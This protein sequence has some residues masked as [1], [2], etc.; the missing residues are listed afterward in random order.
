MIRAIPL[1]LLMTPMLRA[2]KPAIVQTYPASDP[3]AVA[4]RFLPPGS[5]MAQDYLY[6]FRAGHISRRWPAVL[7]GHILSPDADDIVFAYY[8]FKGQRYME[9]TLFLALLHHAT[10]GYELV[11]TLSYRDQFLFSPHAL[12]IVKLRGLPN[13]A[14][15]IATAMGAALGAR[16]EVFVWREGK[17]W[18][19]IFPPNGSVSYFYLFR[20]P[21]GLMV[22][23]SSF[24]HPG[25]NVSPPPEWFQWDGKKFVRIPTPKDALKWEPLE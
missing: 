4:R 8:T 10:G 17:G 21:S 22:A 13:E 2:S 20:R 7:T 18:L 14:V 15:I 11:Y 5:K 6:D 23:L 19:N 3:V 24:R 16:I 12:W 9:K 25:L 1:I